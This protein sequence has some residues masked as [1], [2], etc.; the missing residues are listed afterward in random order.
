MFKT[1][2]AHAA[3]RRLMTIHFSAVGLV[4]ADLGRSFDCY[5]RLGLDLPTDPPDAPHFEVVLPGGMRLMW[6]TIASVGSFDP[7]FVP[8][9]GGPSLAF[10]CGS[11]AGVDETYEVLVAAGCSGALK[12]WDAVWGQRYA[13][14]HDPDGHHIDLFAAL[15]H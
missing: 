14:V 6:D 2:P 5:R 10:D 12:P 13:T 7:D 11:P 15:P 3:Y 1:W 8:G 9:T 4:V